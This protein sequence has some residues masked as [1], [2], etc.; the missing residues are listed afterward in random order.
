[1]GWEYHNRERDERGRF[2]STG[3]TVLLRVRCTPS[4]YEII[5]GRAYARHMCISAYILDLVQR[6]LMRELH[7]IELTG[8]G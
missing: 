7:G 5:R 8:D 2:A 1:M 4:G 6:D 3:K